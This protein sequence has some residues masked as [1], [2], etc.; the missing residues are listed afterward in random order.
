MALTGILN[1]R[2]QQSMIRYFCLLQVSSGAAL[3]PLFLVFQLHTK[4]LNA[5]P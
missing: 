3:L 1:P 4:L 2:C 5:L